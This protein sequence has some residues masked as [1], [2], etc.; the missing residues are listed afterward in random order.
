M[1]ILYVPLDER[2]CN[3]IY[4]EQTA[5]VNQTMNVLSVPQ[6]LLGNK[7]KPANIYGIRS[8]IKKNIVNCSYAIISTEMLL[9]GG[10]LPSR[11][12]HLTEADLNEYEVF[13]RGIKKEFP[14]KKIF[15]SNLIMRTPKYNSSD[16]EPDYYEQY[17]EAIF[18]Y[19]WL[20]DKAAR[21]T[22]DEREE[23]EWNQLKETLPKDVIFDY[24][25]RRAFN[26]QVNLLHVQLVAENIVSFV[27]VPQDDSAPYGYTAM[28]Q[29]KVYSE[30]ANKRLKDRI[31]VYPGA[32]EVG[33]TLLARAYNDH[34]GKT[35]SLFVRYSATF[36]AQIVPLYEDRPINESLKAHVLAAGFRLVDDVKDAEFVLEYNTPGKKMQESWDQ[37]ATKDVT[38]DSYR[39]LLSFVLEI[40]AD[41]AV[42]KKVGIC[43]AAFANGGEM[44][45]IELLDEKGILEEILSYKAWNTNCNSL[46]SSLAGLAFCQATFNKEKV[47]ENLLANIYED[48]FYQAIIRKQ[49]TDNVLPE[50][51][52]NYFYL[53]D[54]ADE[55]SGLVVSLIQKYHRFTLK[56]SFIDDAF[57]IDQ[58]TFPWNRMFEICCTVKNKES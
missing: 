45:L 14:D 17:G 36:G 2:P 54:K 7:K 43:D 31:M 9:Y 24:E 29:S 41:L 28:D 38:Y 32:D 42:G 13:L 52:L 26:V 6:A 10:L 39:H 23:S 12:H 22:L 27:S 30:I 20:K 34:L 33:F 48:L 1:N 56:N 57:T 53:G 19:G 55:I 58:V 35:P 44:E 16:E 46:G 8:F 50:K 5:A 51:W 15:L 25:T 47:K 3:A 4:P 37:L 18:R 11:L 21:D 40:Q 49:I